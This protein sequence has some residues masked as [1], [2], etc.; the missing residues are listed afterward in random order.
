MPLKMKEILK[1][2]QVVASV[3]AVFEKKNVDAN[4]QLSSSTKSFNADTDPS[5]YHT[6]GIIVTCSSSGTKNNFCLDDKISFE[7]AVNDFNSVVEDVQKI[8][9]T[10]SP[11]GNQYCVTTINDRQDQDHI[12]HKVE[13]KQTPQSHDLHCSETQKSAI[14]GSDYTETTTESSDSDEEKQL[15]V[16]ENFDTISEEICRFQ[17]NEGNYLKC[18]SFV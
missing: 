13:I 11:K 2:E 16:N 7:T 6:D 1:N 15:I 17:P 9:N 10:N 5:P 4:K 3:A 8:C 12:F 18:N 14:S